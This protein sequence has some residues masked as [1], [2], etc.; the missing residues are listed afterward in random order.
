[1]WFGAVVLGHRVKDCHTISLKT[2]NLLHWIDILP[3]KTP[4]Q[5]PSEFP[6]A[7]G[8]IKGQMAQDGWKYIKIIKLK[9]SYLMW[10]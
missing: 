7:Q 6:K 3:Q 5:K 2:P 10:F 9:S 4:Y 1:M 8:Q